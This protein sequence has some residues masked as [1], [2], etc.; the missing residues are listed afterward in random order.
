MT[1]KMIKRI[2]VVT[3]VLLGSIEIQ[4]TTIPLDSIKGGLVSF[5]KERN[6]N[7]LLNLSC[8]DLP[9]FLIFDR[10]KQDAIKEGK[11]GIFVFNSNLASGSRI[12]FLLVEKDSFQILDMTESLEINL[13]KLIQF[14]ERNK[15]YSRKNILF[16]TKDF[17]VTYQKNEEYI[18]SFNGII[19]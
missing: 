18:K 7:Q 8:D 10:G 15:Q 12:H 14:F 5:L 3:L 19:K 11:D 9:N 2:L 6:P 16:Y 1:N 4:S 17:I 13:L